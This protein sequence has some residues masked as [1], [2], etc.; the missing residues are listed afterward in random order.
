MSK[1]ITKQK[2]ERT[3]PHLA[4]TLEKIKIVNKRTHYWFFANYDGK[5]KTPSGCSRTV[6][7]G[8][9]I[10][11]LNE[12]GFDV[13]INITPNPSKKELWTKVLEP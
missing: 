1:G 5:Y 9:I 12:N 2:L 3:H 8:A 4:E 10:D 11:V 7:L 13:D 6:S